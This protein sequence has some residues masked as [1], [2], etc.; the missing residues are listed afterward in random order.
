M[1]IYIHDTIWTPLYTII[2]FQKI[3]NMI[4]YHISSKELHRHCGA[5]LYA[6]ITLVVITL[7]KEYSH[8][9]K[10]HPFTPV[11]F[12]YINKLWFSWNISLLIPSL[13][14]STV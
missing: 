14:L 9:I 13:S 1:Q 7:V 2:S 6:I 3:M 8:N 12:S 11:S 10:H 4:L 5:L